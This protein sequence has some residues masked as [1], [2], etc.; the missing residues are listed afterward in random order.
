MISNKR[1]TSQISEQARCKSTGSYVETHAYDDKSKKQA[2]RAFDVY[3]YCVRSVLMT[4]GIGLADN[5][6]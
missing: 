5:Y 6:S 1:I 4:N 3:E 2:L